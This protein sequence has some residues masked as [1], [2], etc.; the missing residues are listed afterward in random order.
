[1]GE[2][3]WSQKVIILSIRARRM[4]L[5]GCQGF[6]ATVVDTTH[7]EKSKPEE[8]AMVREFSDVFLEELLAIPPD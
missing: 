2:G 7:V 3:G 1:M 4:F 6:L 5:S 8:I